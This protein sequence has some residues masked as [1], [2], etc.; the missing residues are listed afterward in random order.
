MNLLQNRKPKEISNAA[1]H[2]LEGFNLPI[3]AVIRLARV[4]DFYL[5][6]AETLG[7]KKKALDADVEVYERILQIY[8]IS[9]STSY[10]S[11]SIYSNKRDF[12]CNAYVLRYAEWDRE[13]DIRIIK[14]ISN[15]S[16]RKDMEIVKRIWPDLKSVTKYCEKQSIDSMLDECMQLDKLIKNG[17]RIDSCGDDSGFWEA[18]IVRLFDWGSLSLCW[19]CTMKNQEIERV[20][21]KI[22]SIFECEIEKVDTNISEIIEYYNDMSPEEYKTG[23]I[24]GTNL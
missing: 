3:S 7:V 21:E 15:E 2:M 22:C 17:V 4:A 10:R 6:G 19:N 11:W 1:V 16:Y 23:I 5:H 13:K 24:K 8:E 20:V 14:G 18:E 9:G 12:K